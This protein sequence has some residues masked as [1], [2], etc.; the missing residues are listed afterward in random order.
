MNR[1]AIVLVG[2]LGAAS[3]VGLVIALIGGGASPAAPSHDGPRDIDP[4]VHRTAD[5]AAPSSSDARAT[6]TVRATVIAC[7]DRPA[8]G[9][10]VT[11]RV[12]A[13]RFLGT[14]DGDGIARVRVPDDL[15][16]GLSA[17]LG[18]FEAALAP[19]RADAV[20]IALCPGATVRGRARDAWGAPVARVALTLVDADGQAIDDAIAEADGS[21]TLTD[22]T[23]GAAA[24]VVDGRAW[25]L[26]PL[27]A[28]EVRALDVIVG[29]VRVVRGFVL[30][31]AGDPVPG[32]RIELLPMAFDAG[33]QPSGG[34]RGDDT[35]LW[36][37]RSDRQG[38]FTF[39]APRTAVRV[40][41]EGGD[42]GRDRAW[43]GEGEGEALV[44][45]V[46]E[47][48]GYVTVLVGDGRALGRVS[49]RT[50]DPKAL[51]ADR[52]WDAPLSDGM[53]EGDLVGWTVD[54]ARRTEVAAGA[55]G[56]P[57]ALPANVWYDAF[58]L[59]A[60]GAERRCARFA[61][62]AGGEV[63]LVCDA[64][65]TPT[66]VLGRVV[67]RDGAP[68]AGVSLEAVAGGAQG[69]AT[70]RA[71]AGP[72]G[73]FEVTLALS[74]PALV[75][76]WVRAPDDATTHVRKNVVV[77][78]G[79]ERDIGDVLLLVGDAAPDPWPD[80]AYGG[81]GGLV[82]F[83]DDG[84]VVL[85]LEEDSPLY[86]DGVERDDTILLVDGMPLSELPDDEALVR[87]RGDPGT[88]VELRLRS[89]R[90]ELYDLVLE[91]RL[92]GAPSETWIEAG[93][94]RIDR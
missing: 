25:S 26:V 11:A 32:V 69:E 36:T 22:P 28:R 24:V 61:V 64:T 45:L 52:S 23:L 85:D 3:L 39:L 56:E 1:R 94:V 49:I 20:V 77:S 13:E 88:H 17:R 71:M 54:R 80:G 15:P 58:T 5:L 2:I 31:L 51:G 60:D 9:A 50:D 16:A 81:I 48:V 21:Y 73:R 70:Q 84:V 83:S 47:P 35:P 18:T 87:L 34:P 78:P 89:A 72:D 67:M 91:R 66:T 63:T 42:L 8:A 7:R 59:A 43:V 82:A 10:T 46:L 27:A 19:S 38:A 92:M 79:D 90:G 29:D 57:L 14:A 76:L 41:A 93:G 30:D 68:A 40:E 12:G 55:L 37:A 53:P 6:R 4:I 75:D 86:L 33:G 74:E 62:A 44:E 65:P